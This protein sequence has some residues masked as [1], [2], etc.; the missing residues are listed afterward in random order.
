MAIANGENDMDKNEVL[1]ILETAKDK[2]G[3][4]PMRLVRQAFEKL[5][6][7]CED[8]ISRQMAIDEANAW[9]LDCFKVQKQNRSCGL[10]RRLEDLPS[11]QLERITC[12][13]CNHCTFSTGAKIY[14]DEL[15]MRMYQWDYC[16]RAERREDAQ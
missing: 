13:Y 16:S 9:L 7:P 2:N 12:K 6:E 8:T 1:K 10:I 11:A 5:P 4:V 15:D 3:E 14:C